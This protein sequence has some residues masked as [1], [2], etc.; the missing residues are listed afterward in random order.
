MYSVAPLKG[1]RRDYGGTTMAVRLRGAVG[2]R[3]KVP[4]VIGTNDRHLVPS[5]SSTAPIQRVCSANDHNEIYSAVC[6]PFVPVPRLQLVQISAGIPIAW[7]FLA[8][9]L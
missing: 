6:A 1:S 2:M 8:Q 3:G 9:W 4:I 7:S 5:N